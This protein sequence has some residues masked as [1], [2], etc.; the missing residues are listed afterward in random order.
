MLR[1]RYILAPAYITCLKLMWRLLIRLDFVGIVR[2]LPQVGLSTRHLWMGTLSGIGHPLFALHSA[3]G[4]PR[5][6]RDGR[7]SRGATVRWIV[8]P[9]GVPFGKGGVFGGPEQAFAGSVVVAEMFV[10]ELALRRCKMM[11]LM[12][13]TAY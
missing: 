11:R 9:I 8:P 7:A 13:R 2:A 12:H 5:R 3:I 6:G 1:E 4:H 10:I